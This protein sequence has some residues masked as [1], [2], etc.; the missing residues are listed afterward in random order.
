MFLKTLSDVPLLNLPDIVLILGSLSDL[1][2]SQVSSFRGIAN[3]LSIATTM[4]S[5][6]QMTILELTENN[7][8]VCYRASECCR[9][10]QL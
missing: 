6:L 2:E 8:A 1:S 7:R 5:L 4:N 3:S 10:S 9:S